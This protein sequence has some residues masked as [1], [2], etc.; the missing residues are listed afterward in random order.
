MAPTIIIST[1]LIL[2]IGGLGVWPSMAGFSAPSQIQQ[3]FGSIE[4]RNAVLGLDLANELNPG[5]YRFLVQ[6]KSSRPPGE[7]HSGRA[8]TS[9]AGSVPESGRESGRS[10]DPSERPSHHEIGGAAQQ[11]SEEVIVIPDRDGDPMAGGRK[12][13]SATRRRGGVV[14]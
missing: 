10:L 6:R 2:G 3:A 12:S 7:S 11:K 13:H 1:T 9:P 5:F 14:K 8:S 4:T